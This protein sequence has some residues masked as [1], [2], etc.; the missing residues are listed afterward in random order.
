MPE[1]HKAA[2]LVPTQKAGIGPAEGQPSGSGG[3]AVPT[4]E[5]CATT[6]YASCRA[7]STN[8]FLRCGGR[9]SSFHLKQI[10]ADVDPW[11]GQH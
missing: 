9:V 7:I 6:S 11:T 5:V 2:Q 4:A 1:N 3:S 10:S 8:A